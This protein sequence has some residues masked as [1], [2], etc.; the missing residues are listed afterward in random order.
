MK[1]RIREVLA[2][3]GTVVHTASPHMMVV[4]AVQRMNEH[5]IG[6]LVVLDG[7]RPVGIFSERDVLRRVVAR[8]RD[9][10]S[11]PV[12]DVMTTNVVV[13]PPDMDVEDT[14]AVITETRC[15][16]LPVMEEGR[17]VGL[18][19]S[20]DLT[21]WVTQDQARDIQDLIEYINGPHAADSVRP[22][23]L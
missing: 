12:R 20:G 9:A 16:H 10:E 3:K 13:V 22:P 5:G 19:S 8:G 11:T 2:S 18:I 15:R 14:M 6:A 1:S 7:Q 21:K 17:M 23:P 4:E